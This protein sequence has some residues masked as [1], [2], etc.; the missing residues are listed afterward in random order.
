MEITQ[1]EVASILAQVVAC[2]HLVDD[3]SKRLDDACVEY[4]QIG[5]TLFPT[6]SRAEEEDTYQRCWLAL[7]NAAPIAPGA[8]T[9]WQD[10]KDLSDQYKAEIE[11]TR[12]MWVRRRNLFRGLEHSLRSRLE[13]NTLIEKGV[14]TVTNYNITIKDIVGP[15][16]VLSSLD[17]VVQTVKNSPAMSSKNKDELSALIEDLKSSLANAPATHAEDAAVVSEQAQLIADE[18]SKPSPRLSSLKIKASGLIEAAKAMA[19]VVPMAIDIA[20]KI[21]VFVTNPFT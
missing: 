14:D 4:Y 7:N 2:R 16:N 11:R 8:L 10:I 21:A 17:H 9:Q 15:V 3:Y 12:D 5:K 6:L 20:Q 18:L 19:T 1:T 13:L